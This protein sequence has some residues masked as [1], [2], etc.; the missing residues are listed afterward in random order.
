MICPFILEANK[1]TF[2]S[3]CSAGEDLIDEG[4]AGNMHSYAGFALPVTV[5]KNCLI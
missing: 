1:D 5:S 4:F 2:N 3:L